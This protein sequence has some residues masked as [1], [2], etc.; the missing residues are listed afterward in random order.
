MNPDMGISTESMKMIE[1]WEVQ[2]LYCTIEEYK[3]AKKL[4]ERI[5]ELEDLI[6]TRESQNEV[7]REK[8]ESLENENII[9]SAQVQGMITQIEHYNKRLIKVRIRSFIN[10]IFSKLGYVREK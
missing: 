2:R 9:L 6:Y 8:V 10:S 7:L 5:I 3:S 1:Q 4:A